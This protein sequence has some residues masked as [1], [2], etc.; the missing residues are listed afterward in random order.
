[1]VCLCVS[2]VCHRFSVAHFLSSLL[3]SVC[4]LF[5][6]F[7]FILF[8][9]LLCRHI[10]TLASSRFVSLTYAFTDVNVCILT[11]NLRLKLL[12]TQFSLTLQFCHSFRRDID[13]VLGLN[14]TTVCF[15][16]I[17]NKNVSQRPQT[18]KLL[19]CFI[20]AKFKIRKTFVIQKTYK[21]T[22]EFE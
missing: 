22:F 16:C 7:R 15:V 13:F 12:T 4:L 14:Y 17:Q 3:I 20:S 6:S 18:H 8:I 19:S 2:F 10:Y 1:M 21:N 9:P 5:Y 11:S